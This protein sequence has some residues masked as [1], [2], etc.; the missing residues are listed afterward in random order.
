MSYSISLS[1]EDIMKMDKESLAQ[2]KSVALNL[3]S[4][5]INATSKKDEEESK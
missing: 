3:V 4:D 5:C 1:T 2:L